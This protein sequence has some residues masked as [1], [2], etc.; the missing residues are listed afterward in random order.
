MLE[1]L[2]SEPLVRTKYVRVDHE[3]WPGI[4][5][6]DVVR[7]YDAAA[8]LPVTPDGQV[9][10]VRQFRPA[11]RREILEIP[12]GLLDEP[13]EGP[14]AC[15]ARE[16]FEETG[17]RHTSMTKLCEILPSP[18]SWSE[19][20]HLYLADTESQAAGDA[21]SGI[22]VVRRPF[23]ELVAEARSGELEDA[24]TALAVLLADARQ[25]AG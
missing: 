9:L 15:V 14:E 20:V 13:G 5:E 6:R 8:V 2:E 18:G 3:V 19:R 4:G 7:V 22:E 21:E 12:A 17:F 23:D 25:G 1:P 11:A 24:K 10:L 16:L